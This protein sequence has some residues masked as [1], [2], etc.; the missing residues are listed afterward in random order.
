MRLIT[1]TQYNTDTSTCQ[2]V[3]YSQALHYLTMSD[4]ILINVIHWL[5]IRLHL[6]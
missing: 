3:F 2:K 6:Y 1:Y 5:K 4:H